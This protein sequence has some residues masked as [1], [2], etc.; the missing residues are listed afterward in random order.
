M[1]DTRRT[2]V[3]E[4]L[5]AA[6]AAGDAEALGEIFR[7]D[8]VVWHSTDQLDMTLPA[9]QE[10]LRSIS[11]IATADVQQTGLHHTDTGFVLTL[12]STYTLKTGGTTT[13]H[14][15]QVVDLDADDQIVRVD[16]YL[17][18]AGLDPLIQALTPDPS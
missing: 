11:S 17:D 14:A 3:A 15:A 9:L 5:V 7:P 2:D 16:E 8:A 13:F 12:A 1:I 4:R 18:S 10:M 6:I